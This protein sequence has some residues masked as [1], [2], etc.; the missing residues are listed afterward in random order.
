MDKD[1]ELK[2]S[3]TTRRVR[4]VLFFGDR[5]W[6]AAMPIIECLRKEK[7]AHGINLL[8]VTGGARGADSLAT[9]HARAM[10]IRVEEYKAD[11]ERFGK[12]AGPIRNQVM[13]DSGLDYAWGFHA[14]I[15]QSKGTKDM[16]LRLAS[17]GVPYT[18]VT[19]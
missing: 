9:F 13:L 14:N 15:E 3:M 17:A 4:R 7:D 11:W 19:G 18:I 2:M 10:Q 1:N 16:A 12:A 6:T 8:V 5:N